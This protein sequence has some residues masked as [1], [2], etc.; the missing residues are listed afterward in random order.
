[1]TKCPSTT[2][3]HSRNKGRNVD[4]TMLVLV[5]AMCLATVVVV[6]WRASASHE[7]MAAAVETL[8]DKALT[9]R[10]VN[11][12]EAQCM[13]VL[14]DLQKQSGEQML[15]FTSEGRDLLKERERAEATIRGMEMEMQV[16]KETLGNMGVRKRVATPPRQPMQPETVGA[17]GN[18]EL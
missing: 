7:R 8:F 15:A 1:M 10:G 13:N 3:R 9:Y 16:Y 18:E 11:S 2:G 12:P 17:F 14:A 4:T 6:A 5:V